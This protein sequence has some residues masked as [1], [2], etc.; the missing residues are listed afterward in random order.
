M[1]IKKAIFPVGGLGT[2]FLPATKAIPKEMLPIVDKPLIQYAV[3]EAIEAGCEEFIFVTGRGKSSI[4]DHFDH[5]FELEHTLATH[6]KDEALAIAKNMLSSPG[7]ITYVRQQEPAGLGHAVWCARHLVHDEPVAI[8]LADDLINGAPGCLKQMVD[9]YTSGN[10]IAVMEVE[11]RELKSYGVIDPGA[12]R[13]PLIEVKGLIEKPRP[14]E[15]PSRLAVIGRYIIEPGVFAALSRKNRSVGGEIQLTD[16]LA[17]RV[18]QV[19]FFGY[20][21][22][23]SRYDCGSKIGFLKANVAYALKREEIR[24]EL[25]LWLKDQVKDTF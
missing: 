14:N 20:R 4:E 23:G 6:H 18:G 9:R 15:A 12:R 19:P 22:E 21:F 7:S 2:R 11:P 25:T 17:D 5:A 24:D 10:M 3:E 13:G 1:V 16:S 8:I